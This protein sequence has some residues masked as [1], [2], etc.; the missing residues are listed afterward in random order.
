MRGVLF[1]PGLGINLYSIGSATDAGIEVHFANNTVVF[2]HNK[3]VIM[4]GKRAGKEA[5]YHLNIRAKE[6]YPR[7]EQAL[8]GVR[9]EPLSIWHQRFGHLNNKSLLKMASMGSVKGLALFKDQL[10]SSGNCRGCLQGKMCRAPFTSTRI[11]AT[12]VGQ[13]IHSDVCGP[14]QVPTPFGERFY[15]AFKDEFSGWTEIKLIRNKCEVPKAFKDFSAKVETET[16]KK[17]KILRSDGGGE[18]IGTELKDWLEKAG[19]AHQVTPP[20]TPQLNGVAE[21]A[22]RTIVESAR[23][24]M[25]GRKVPLELWGLAMQCA[26]YVQ[27]RS[28]PS[29]SKVTPF[30]LWF[31]RKPDISH[32]KVFGCLVF[33]HV[34]DEKRRKL[35]SKA[36]EAMMVGYVEGSTS[37]YQIW[38]P[39]KRKLTTSRDV[40]FEEQSM[41]DMPGS[42]TA[43]EEQDYYS[44]LPTESQLKPGMEANPTDQ[45]GVRP[46][47]QP[48]QQEEAVLP[49]NQPQGEAVNPAQ[50]EEIIP[51]RGEDGQHQNEQI[52][53]PFYGFDPDPN[54]VQTHRRSE[55][56]R[57]RRGYQAN[58]LTVADEAPST[59]VY[60]K[61][62]LTYRQA[63]SSSDAHLWDAAIK[64][65]YSSLIKN[66]TWELTLL[67]PGRTAIKCK[68]VFDIKPGYEGVDERYKARL[69]ALGCSQLPG[70]DFD[71]TFAPVVKLSTFRLCL[72]IAAAENLEIL[73]IDVKTAFLYGRLKEVIYMRQPEGFVVPGREKEVCRL[74]KSLYGLKQA[75]RVWNTE[76]NDAIMEYGLIRSEEDQCVYYRLK[77]EDWI[78]V[79]FFVDDGVICG[80]SK[81]IVENFANHLKKKFEIRILPAGRFLGMTINRNRIKGELSISQPDFVDAILKKFKMEGCNPVKTPAEPGLQLSLDMSPQQEKEKEDMKTIPYKEAV[82]ALL[83]L[84]T[85]TRP[86]IS[87]AVGQVAKFTQNPGI[88]HWKAVKRIL[89]Y[90]AGTRSYGILYSQERGA[91]VT[92]YTDADHAGDLDERVSTSGCVYL[93]SGGSISWFS[94]KQEC[95]SLSTTESEFVAASEAAKEA[96]WIR[97]FLKEIQRRGPEPIPLL[98]DNQGAIRCAH[99]PELHRKMKHIDIRFRYVKRAQE[100]GVIEASYV[101]SQDQVADIFTKALPLPKFQYLREKLGMIDVTGVN[102]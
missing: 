83:Y 56:L 102:V 37:C 87:Y 100:S 95:N 45:N 28:T 6:Y 99:N 69:V 50:G 5:L 77:G 68:W 43:T 36:V 98:C 35:D 32:L 14:I 47:E 34:P 10:D 39:T 71:Q 55:R 72:A 85:T 62:D 12:G 51:A 94:R 96:T 48:A 40:T 19:I 29:A 82:G 61:Q 9:V 3:V 86:D 53:D 93:C 25:Y 30:E 18:Y 64:D 49:I 65:E 89:R 33:V 15:V 31:K 90:T 79:L 84:S 60:G 38:D 46:A 52:D 2:S 76:L 13:V 70:L 88:Q 80:T 20:Y 23:S 92:G 44:I 91:V 67:P 75:P 74:I 97:S 63:L 27:N 21:R 81:G 101:N 26:V 42:Q 57:L 54:A 17:V 11:K 66:E 16:G 8:K 59:K 1:V 73:Q 24:Q 78:A 41:V 7:T 58:V 22:N 4:E